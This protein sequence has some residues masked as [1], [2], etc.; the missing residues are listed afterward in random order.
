[1]EKTSFITFSPYQRELEIKKTARNTSPN[2]QREW[3]STRKQVEVYEAFV[4]TNYDT[5][6]YDAT[7]VAA[8]CFR[9]AKV[10]RT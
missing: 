8:N 4:A 1:M 2:A 10:G 7:P 9:T 5:G 3:N 6:K